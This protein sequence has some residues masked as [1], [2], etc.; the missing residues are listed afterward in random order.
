MVKKH[1]WHVMC[2]TYGQ[3]SHGRAQFQ[4]RALY[5]S[6][7]Y[8]Y[9]LFM[10]HIIREATEIEFH[11]NNTKREDGFCLSHLL[12]EGTQETPSCFMWH[13][14]PGSLACAHCPFRS[15]ALPFHSTHNPSPSWLILSPSTSNSTQ[16]ASTPFQ[17]PTGV[18]FPLCPLAVSKS[19]YNGHFS[20]CSPTAPSRLGLAYIAPHFPCM[21]CSACH[22]LDLLILWSQRQRWCTP[23]ICQA[24]SKLQGTITQNTIHFRRE[25]VSCSLACCSKPAEDNSKGGTNLDF[26]QWLV[27]MCY[28][29]WI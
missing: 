23:P 21:V 19:H 4:F 25:A 17:V 26:N 22:L 18:M 24:L 28:I 12:L 14:S 27:N 16:H 6:P 13:G 2:W 15:W 29:I 8:Q 10:N 5:L 20:T 3:I 7:G 1:H 9:H 11:P